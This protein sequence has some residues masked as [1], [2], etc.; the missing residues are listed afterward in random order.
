MR[1][2]LKR[3]AVF[4]GVGHM[5]KAPGTWGT[6]AAVPIAVG[7]S[8]LG[9]FIYMGTCVLF[10]ILA[11]IACDVYEQDKG[12][13]DSP[14]VVVDEVIGYL[15]TVTWLPFTWQTFV[16]GFLLFRLF[17]IWKPL[18][19]GMLDRRMK[20]GVGTVMDDVAAGIVAN[21]ILQ[22]VYYNTSWLGSRWLG[23]FS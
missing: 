14:E 22:M 12:D 3:L 4:F 5:K 7:L 15:I 23:G 10:L 8:Y 21:A 9:P 11:I 16:F 20:R 17:D 1:S 2:F 13:H 18:F 19:I 6:L